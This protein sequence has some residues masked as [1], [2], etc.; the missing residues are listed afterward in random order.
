MSEVG[1]LVLVADDDRDI[2]ELLRY[3]LERSG[4][5]VLVAVD[6]EQAERL[7]LEHEPALCL[8]DVM[9]PLVDGYELTRRLRANESTSRTPIILL[10]ARTREAD[11]ERGFAAGADD[12]I[13]KPFS[14]EELRARVQAALG[15]R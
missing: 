14:P 15:R 2:R 10:T 3:R 13:K 1:P 7:A 11:V 9:M 12:Y 4:Y 6:G 5:E 8:F